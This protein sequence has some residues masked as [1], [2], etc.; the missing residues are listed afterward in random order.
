MDPGGGSDTD[1]ARRRRSQ[2]AQA[3][4]VAPGGIGDNTA[5]PIRPRRSTAHEPRLGT[6]RHRRLRRGG[7]ALLPAELDRRS[8]GGAAH[9]AAR[10]G[11]DR[12]GGPRPAGEPR[13]GSAQGRPRD[14]REA[15]HQR[16]DGR[17][18]AR[19]LPGGAGRA[20]GAARPRPQSQ[21]GEPDHPHVRAPRHRQRPHRARARLQLARRGLRQRLPGQRGGGARGAAGA[22]EPGRRG[23]VG[24]RQGHAL[25]SRAST[26]SAS[27]RRRK[28]TR[29]RRCTWI[30]AARRAPTR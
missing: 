3:S 30:A 11:D 24:H 9:A 7:G 29:G 21:R 2:G 25:P 23:A 20:G 22:V 17:L 1:S 8:S 18:P 28:T 16:G 6:P 14:G 26:R 15:G 12:G 19:A 27:R 5:P 13:P 4:L 10:R